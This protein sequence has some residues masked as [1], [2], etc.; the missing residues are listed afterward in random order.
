[1]AWGKWLMYGIFCLSMW[2]KSYGLGKVA[3]VWDFPPQYVGETPYAGEG[4]HVWDYVTAGD[5][6]PEE[7]TNPEADPEATTAVDD[8]THDVPASAADAA[9]KPAEEAE[10]DAKEADAAEDT[11][12]P[13][14]AD[15]EGANL[16][17][18]FVLE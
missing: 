17:S 5:A 10:A 18:T 2:E 7:E 3:H 6:K 14:N 1:M 15:A 8:A 12:A 9:E 4:A 13:E 16:R 11:M